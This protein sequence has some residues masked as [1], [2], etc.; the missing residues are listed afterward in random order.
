MVHAT[1]QHGP[2]LACRMLPGEQIRPSVSLDRACAARGPGVT[3]APAARGLRG[4]AR[5]CGGLTKRLQ[6]D[7]MR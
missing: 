5:L 4:A 1:L 7:H 3:G 2:G 6:E